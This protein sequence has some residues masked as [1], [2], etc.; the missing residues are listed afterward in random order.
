MDARAAYSLLR[1][2]H[3][4]NT[5]RNRAFLRFS[6]PAAARVL[7]GYRRLKSLVTELGRPGVEVRILER[8]SGEPAVE[9]LARRL[10]YHRVVLLSAWELR[11]LRD[12]MGFSTRPADSTDPVA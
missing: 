5:S 11:F 10:L 6:E 4:G 3:L 9:V 1:E 12:E 8:P 7:A 2:L